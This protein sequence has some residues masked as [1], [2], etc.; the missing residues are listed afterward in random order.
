MA[1]NTLSV[2]NGAALHNVRSTKFL[3]QVRLFRAD[4]LSRMEYLDLTVG[5]L[6]EISIFCDMV[7][8]RSMIV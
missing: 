2:N 5:F 6:L 8:L 7:R 4:L 3:E 1:L